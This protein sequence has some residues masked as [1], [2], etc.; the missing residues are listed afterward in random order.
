MSEFFT[1]VNT[2]LSQISIVPNDS[3]KPETQQLHLRSAVLNGWVKEYFSISRYFKMISTISLKAGVNPQVE[4][5]FNNVT[6]AR[7]RGFE[8]GVKADMFNRFLTADISYTSLDPVD[9]GDNTVLKFRPR[10]LFYASVA[11]QYGSGR[12]NSATAM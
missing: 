1:S 3:L 10:H 8:F 6:R 11:A 9:L 5:Q 7:I 2:G 4:I 12:Q